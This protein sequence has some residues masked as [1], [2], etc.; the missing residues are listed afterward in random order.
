MEVSICFSSRV[1]NR[2]RNPAQWLTM[3]RSFGGLSMAACGV[4]AT[5]GRCAR[6]V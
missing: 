2:L 4:G 5:V 1:L 6:G 3:H